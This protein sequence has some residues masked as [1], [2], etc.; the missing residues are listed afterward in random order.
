MTRSDITNAVRAVERYAPTPTERLWQAI[1][2]MLSY[3]DGTK[4]FGITYVQMPTSPTRLIIGVRY[5]G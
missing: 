5:L 2:K 3:L 1:M 4:R